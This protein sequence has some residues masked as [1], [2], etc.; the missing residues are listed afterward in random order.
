MEYWGHEGFRGSQEAVIHQLLSGRDVLALMPTGGGKSICYQVPAMAREGLCIVVSPLVALIHDQVAQL[1][2]RGIKAIA[3]GGGIS[4][5]ELGHLLDNCLYGNYKF[6]YLSP[7]RLQQPMVQ[8]RIQGMN[9][10][11]LAV[12]EAHCISQWGNDF[13]PAY[14][15]CSQLRELRPGVPLVALTATATPRVLGDIVENL[16]LEEAEIFKDSYARTNIAFKVKH[17]EDK[18]GQL[19]KYLDKNPGSAIIYVRSRKRCENLSAYLNREG[20]PSAYYHGGL[21]HREKEGKRI[22]WGHGEI[23]AMVATNAFGMGVDKADVRLVVHDRA[24][25]SLESYYQEAGRAG[26]D[27]KPATS[28]ILDA[29]ADREMA[30]SLY[31]SALPTVEH[32][33]KVYSKLNNH[34]QISYGEL[35]GTPLPLR[36]REFCDRYGFPPALALNVLRILDQNS[37]LSLVDAYRERNLLRFVGSKGEIFGYLERNRGSA[38]V[39]QAILRTY[40][41]ITQYDTPIDL[42]LLTRKTGRSES[43]IKTVVQQLADDGLAQYSSQDSDLEIT[44]LVPREDDHTIYPFARKIEKFNRIKGENLRAML[45]Y[46]GNKKICRNRVLLNYFGENSPEKCGS[47][48]ICTKGEK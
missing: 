28:V 24:P 47:C 45:G 21:P 46:I 8:E 3:L 34:F 42:Q 40:G 9:V 44:F 48:D 38:P 7:E 17:T 13:R 14:L 10:N 5:G 20:I 2:A 33:K 6:L 11:L 25:D 37:V 39:V 29:K 19:K 26:R 4:A 27:G 35:P 32:V 30:E 18:L 16:H 31:L 43:A 36:F 41:G 15:H 1:K 12:D 22:L 23:R